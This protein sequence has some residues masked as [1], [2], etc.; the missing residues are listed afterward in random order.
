[1]SEATTFVRLRKAWRPVDDTRDRD[2]ADFVA[3]YAPGHRAGL[4]LRAEC[5][6]TLISG[7]HAAEGP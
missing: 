1:M 6:L 4:H 7:K 5:R 3:Y 2:T